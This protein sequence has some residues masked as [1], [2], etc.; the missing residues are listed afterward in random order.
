MRS[1]VIL[2]VKIRVRALTHIK[3]DKVMKYKRCQEKRQR[4][5]VRNRTPDEAKII[6]GLPCALNED[7][8][9][10]SLKHPLLRSR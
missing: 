5:E 7:S 2:L 8:R 3:D 4:S 9:H 10:T 6:Q 1:S